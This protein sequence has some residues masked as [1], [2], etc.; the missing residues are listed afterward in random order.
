[1]APTRVAYVFPNS[2]RDLIAQCSAGEAPD[3]HLLGLNHLAPF[4]I[5]AQPRE[6]ALDRRAAFLPTR[7]R[8]HLR[9]LSLPWELRDVDAVF[10]P[11]ANIVPLTARL[12]GRPRVVVYNFGLNTILRRGSAARRRVLTASLRR[13]ACVA[14]LGASQRDELLE[15]TGFDPDHV[16]VALHGVD[17]RFFAPPDDPRERLV[18]AIGRDLARD[19]ATLVEATRTI[20]A[21]FVFVVLQRNLDRID[22]P[23]NVEVRERIPYAELR[24]LYRRASVAVVALRSADY[25]YGSEGSGVSAM[26][27]AQASGTPLVAS[28]RPIVRDYVRDGDS[29]LIVPPEHAP[30]L[31]D[32]IARILGDA[33]LA[34][35]LGETGRRRVEQDHTMADMAARLA[36]LLKQAAGKP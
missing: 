13:A 27:E 15:L 23:P 31:S 11:L 26:L 12:R 33:E 34:R 3:T 14:C 6:P 16:A 2:R 5:D 35:R 28:D 29:G 4:G 17:E 22:V 30:A 25:P 36:P 21:R 10:T 20:D 7:A 19:Y 8:W 18:I 24:D 32:A 9:E 1:M